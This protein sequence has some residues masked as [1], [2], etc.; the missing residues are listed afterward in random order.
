M[1]FLLCVFPF[2]LILCEDCHH[3]NRSGAFR[4]GIF[5]RPVEGESC[6]FPCNYTVCSSQI[7]QIFGE[8]FNYNK[9]RTLLVSRVRVGVQLDSDQFVAP[10]YRKS[11]GGSSVACGKYFDF[12]PLFFAF[13]RALP[14]T[15][16]LT[17][18]STWLSGKSPKTIQFQYFQCTTSAACFEGIARL[19]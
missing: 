9:L 12:E 15:Q 14:L 17:T 8:G 11:F 1:L 6:N 18:C 19:N 7:S 3:R 4:A 13:F 16:E 5:Q 2:L 10:G